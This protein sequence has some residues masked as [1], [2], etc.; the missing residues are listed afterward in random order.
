MSATLLKIHPDNPSQ[1]RIDRV[2]NSLVEGGIIIYPTDTVYALG[3]DL[4]NKRAVEKLCRIK[5]VKPGKMNLSFV[6]FD[7][8]NVSEYAAGITTPV[9]K[10]MKKAVPGPYT[11]IL[12]ANSKVP[13]IFEIN[14]KSVGIRIPDH[15][16]PREIVRALGHPIISASLKDRDS[17]VEYSTDPEVIFE[18]YKKNVEIVID[19]GYGGNVPSSVVDLSGNEWEVIR[20]GLGDLSIFY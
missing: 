17:L 11:F 1:Q 15:N 13:K 19:A 16:I 12:K 6:C 4:Y 5:G 8:S 20:E 3:C 10:V 18:E 9:F 2:V 14:K 7:L